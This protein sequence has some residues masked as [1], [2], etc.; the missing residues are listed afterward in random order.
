MMTQNQ[1]AD[2]EVF[3]PQLCQALEATVGE[4]WLFERGAVSYD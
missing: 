3:L 4:R 2:P 1:L